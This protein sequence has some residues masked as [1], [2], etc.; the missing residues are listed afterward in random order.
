MDHVPV[1]PREGE[2]GD[3]IEVSVIVPVHNATET[4]ESTIQSA[5]SQ[6]LDGELNIS[7]YICC[8]DD[9]SSDDSWSILTEMKKSARNDRIHLLIAKSDDGVGRGA[10]YARN[11]AVEMRQDSTAKHNFLC[12]LDSDDLMHPTRVAQQTKYLLSLSQEERDRTLLGSTFVR[13]PPDSTWHYAQWANNLTDERLVLER[14]REVSILQ[15]TW[16]MCRTRF[17]H[18]GGYIEA[19][20]TSLDDFISTQKQHDRLRLVHDKETLQTLRVAE[21]LRLFHAHVHARGLLRL[22]RTTPLVT[23]RHRLESQS[24]STP[25]RL[26]LQLRVAAFERT[27]IP[28]WPQFVVWGA[29]RDGKD[30]VKAMQEHCH[31]IYCFVDV[32][33]KKLE[34]TYVNRELGLDIPIVHFAH[35]VKDTSV[36]EKLLEGHDD[37]AGYGKIDKSKTQQTKKDAPVPTKRRRLDTKLDLNLLQQLPVVVCVAMYRT[38]GALEHNVS[39]IGRTEGKDLWHFS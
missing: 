30:F 6:Q 13:D 8:Y 34:R 23:Y 21:D 18:L 31:R 15:P 25:R 38:N 32:D 17:N 4:L 24:Y 5:L 35:L 37:A 20:T 7:I 1:P 26:L 39:L 16:M 10:G 14:F 11:R 3:E 28:N 2:Q 36:R 29:G 22:I 12:L 27:I 33:E 9:G 19:P